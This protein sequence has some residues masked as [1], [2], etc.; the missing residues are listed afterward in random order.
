MQRLGIPVLSLRW[1][2][3]C[4]NRKMMLRD[5]ESIFKLVEQFEL[6]KNRPG[7]IIKYLDVVYNQRNFVS[8]MNSRLAA[9]MM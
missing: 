1:N 9:L 6:G 8:L 2:Q 3:A 7:E 5:D 4:I